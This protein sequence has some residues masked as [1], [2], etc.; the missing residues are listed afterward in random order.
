[1]EEL[2]VRLFMLLVMMCWFCPMSYCQLLSS[3][4]RETAK[5]LLVVLVL[6]VFVVIVFVFVVIVSALVVFAVIVFDMLI[7][8]VVIFVVPVFESMNT[9]FKQNSPFIA[10]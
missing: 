5:T 6:I 9:V 4:I 7:F 3:S 8:V 2:I 1:M 10:V